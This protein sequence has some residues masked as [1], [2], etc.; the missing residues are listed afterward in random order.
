MTRQIKVQGIT[1][2]ELAVAALVGA[3]VLGMTGF[4]LTTAL[5]SSQQQ[6]GVGSKGDVELTL[7]Q[8]QKFI[9]RLGRVASDCE[10]V[11]SSELTC[12]V[13]FNIPPTGVTTTVRFILNGTDLLYEWC[14]NPPTCTTW[15]T[16]TTYPNI[17]NF[18]VCDQSMLVP[19]NTCPIAPAMTNLAP[20]DNFFRYQLTGASTT[21]TGFTFQ[22]RSAFFSRNPTPFPG[23]V[24]QWGGGE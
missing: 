21:A 22:Y 23:V 7:L 19:T 16:K 8:A 15:E 10:R 18:E 14:S 17:S 2:I 9:R 11:S 1:L 12:E 13:D 4:L 24:F 20:S 6:T 3:L 5:R